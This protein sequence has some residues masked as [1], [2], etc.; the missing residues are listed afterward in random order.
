MEYLFVYLKALQIRVFAP[1]PTRHAPTSFKFAKI[2]LRLPSFG[3]KRSTLRWDNCFLK[4]QNKCTVKKYR[5]LEEVLKD[6]MK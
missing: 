3:K 2:Q 4:L 1:I 6:R 5:G